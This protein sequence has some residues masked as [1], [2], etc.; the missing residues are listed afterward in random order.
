[1]ALPSEESAAR[2][3]TTC[4]TLSELDALVQG[5]IDRGHLRGSWPAEV[6][7]AENETRRRLM[8]VRK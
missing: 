6:I 1:M 4:A 2:C 3:I 5:W 8:G 7:R